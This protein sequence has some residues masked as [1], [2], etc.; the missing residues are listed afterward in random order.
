MAHAATKAPK[1]KYTPDITALTYHITSKNNALYKQLGLARPI[2]NIKPAK[3]ERQK[4]QVNKAAPRASSSLGLS[5]MNKGL[6]QLKARKS[7]YAPRGLL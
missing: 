6:E 4:V 5:R 7:K 2:L 3:A 1:F